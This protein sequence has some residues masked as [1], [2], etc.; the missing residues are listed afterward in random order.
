M[1]SSTRAGL[2]G[3]PSIERSSMKRRLVAGGIATLLVATF[4]S[5]AAAA[6]GCTASQLRAQL[7]DTIVGQGLPYTPLVRGKEA[8]VRF[9]FSLPECASDSQSILMKSA[10]LVVGG[11]AAPGEALTAQNKFSAPLTTWA[12]GPSA[13]GT[14]DPLFLI[15]A[16]R[17]NPPGSGAFEVSF[18][19]TFT[20][21]PSTSTT[22]LKP[23]TLPAVKALVNGATNAY[24]VLAVPMG[25]ANYFNPAL[26]K[27]NANPQLT[28]AGADAF[29]TGLASAS[30]MLPVAN[31]VGLLGKGSGAGVRYS[32][33]L[34]ALVNVGPNMVDQTDDGIANA[35]YC[36]SGFSNIETQL[37]A[38]AGAY[39]S[40]ANPELAEAALGV[41]DEALSRDTC[42]QGMGAVGGNDAWVRALYP[43]P[44]PSPTIDPMKT[45]VIT[46][47]E[48]G[49]NRG[50]VPDTRDAF[51]D[52][53]HSPTGNADTF[54]F[55]GKGYNLATRQFL[56]DAR[57]AMRFT[58]PEWNNSSGLY[59]K[60]DWDL[61]YCRLGGPTN[62]ECTDSSSDSMPTG[63]ISAS[64]QT[65]SVVVGRTDFTPA[66]TTVTYSTSDT[67][68]E[69]PSAP[70]SRLR[71]VQIDGTGT[72]LSDH[73]VPF[74]SEVE[75]PHVGGGGG[76]ASGSGFNGVF[77]T[78]A[79][80]TRWEL[81]DA[82]TGAVLASSDE[83]STPQ[84]TGEIV[85][86]SPEVWGY[87]AK[88]GNAKIFEY[89]LAE[90]TLVSSCIPDESGPGNPLD[91]PANGRGLALDSD[92]D[93]F[94]TR[95]AD[96]TIEDP[97]GGDPIV[98]QKQG[99]GLIH[100]VDFRGDEG[101]P[102]QDRG[103]I[104]FGDGPG[105]DDQD[106]LGALD[107]DPD[108]GTLW[109]AG[110]KPVETACLEG[111]TCTPIRKSFL[112]NVDPGTGEIIDSCW[113]PFTGGGDGN[114]TLAVANLDVGQ[115]TQKYLLTDGGDEVSD[116]GAPVQL[117]AVP[118]TGC[119]DG[120][121]AE[122]DAAFPRLGRY[123]GIDY[124]DGRLIASNVPT[125]E[126]WDLGD[127]PFDT[128]HD[129]MDTP[130]AEDPEVIEDITLRPGGLEDEQ[131]PSTPVG[132]EANV[133]DDNLEDVTLDWF[134]SCRNETLPFRLNDEVNEAGRG[135][136]TVRTEQLCSNGSEATVLVRPNDQHTAGDFT[137]SGIFS[138]LNHT[139]DADITSAPL[140]VLQHV[141]IHVEGLGSDF[142]DGLVASQQWFVN[143]PGGS[144]EF[145]A[146]GTGRTLDLP[147]GTAGTYVI[148]LVV[149]D[150]S[151]AQ[152]T[153]ET[154]VLS[155]TDAD[156]DG[157]PA[158]QEACAGGSDSDP[159]DRNLDGDLDGRVNGDDS[160]PCSPD[161]VAL[162]TGDFDPDSLQNSSSGSPIKM[163]VFLKHRDPAQ[164]VGSTVAIT[165]VNGTPVGEYPTPSAP[166]MATKWE[167]DGKGIWFALFDR[168][169]VITWMQQNGF[170]PGTV[171]FTVSGD[172]HSVAPTPHTWRFSAS[173]FTKFH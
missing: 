79:N 63:T 82:G 108:D 125:T 28:Q 167:K 107:V 97:L 166:F 138:A 150:S 96:V 59:E 39:N 41:I 115:G 152:N 158:S 6:A 170:T 105:G 23:E 163:S 18:T 4:Y 13:D 56:A 117:L 94:Y 53:T 145:V 54:S 120:L 143:A 67:G 78:Q 123:S 128:I 136:I 32:L 118:A 151:G 154:V 24:K 50:V 19:L 160:S 147:G 110:Y 127:V 71:F 113:V 84:I 62:T 5:P 129:R 149:T 36:D 169:A 2:F 124:E 11:G 75:E 81:R 116:P 31:G 21:K 137:E 168:Q 100:K 45:G 49:H 47:M 157:V 10:S 1:T 90:H 17:L 135:S 133:T 164:I 61:I 99:D 27:N 106:D 34:G 46:A 40:A 156:N 102:C 92:G 148:R 57:N 159:F 70:R 80:A 26:A 7:R 43:A 141:A 25:D 52:G 139:P 30:R 64:V 58:P 86:R 74:V 77:P 20:Q 88:F 35:T 142:E 104:D 171:W 38:L 87:Q 29:T 114:D 69:A 153:E 72:V 85:Q 60:A 12:S 155:D 44:V 134:Y 55:A 126:L 101:G 161:P 98:N 33:N 42:A 93:F 37:T 109:A 132:L 73:G 119:T 103:T 76:E 68:L 162:A 22:D 146:S 140:R 8:L 16:D 91:L 95:L 131:S 9:R 111:I 165:H 121:M 14:G 3:A 15:P 51:V 48:W 122:E 130:G 144:D 173:D 65:V 83:T 172:G 66:G 112:Y 89:D